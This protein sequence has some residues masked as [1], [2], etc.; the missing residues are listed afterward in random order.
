MSKNKFFKI[1]FI[2]FAII[3]TLFI[4]HIAR[5]YIIISKIASKQDNSNEKMLLI[6]CSNPNGTYS[7]EQYQKGGKILQLFKTKE[8]T[9]VYWYDE[10]TKEAIIYLPDQKVASTY[11]FD[12]LQHTLI[13]E[14]FI[15][16][17]NMGDKLGSALFSWITS[18]E[19]N[20]EKCYVITPEFGITNYINKENGRLVKYVNLGNVML[21]KEYKNKI[22]KEIDLNKPNLTE[23]DVT[24][25]IG[26]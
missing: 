21:Y 14:P 5:N 3:I 25:V 8:F 19:V 1:I 9:T 17:G 23:Y 13:F 22:P 7:I 4:I 26:F 16:Y 24:N 15:K 2:V 20:G 6:E 11:T 12:D 18:D 10:N